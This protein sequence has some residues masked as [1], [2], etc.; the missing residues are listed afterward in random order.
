MIEDCVRHSSIALRCLAI[1]FSV[2][3]SPMVAVAA[4]P[5]PWPDKSGPTFDGHASAADSAGVPTTWNE[6]TG[7]NIAWKINV[8]G[9]GHSTP[10]IGNGRL[11]FTSATHDGKRQYVYCVDAATGSVLHHK[12]LF[13]N[14]NPEP[15][16]NDVNTYASCS[17]YL[18]PDAVYVHFGSYGTARLDP[19]T[20]EVVWQRRDLQARHY[21][22]PGSSPIVFENLLILT[23][24][25]IDRHYVTALDKRTG[26][27]VW[28]T[29]TVVM[30]D[31]VPELISIGSRAAYGYDA[32]TGREL[33]I[34]THSDF[35]ACARPLFSPGVVYLNAGTG[36]HLMAL[37][38]D[39]STRGDVTTSHM[40]WD[41]KKFVSKLSSPVLVGGQLYFVTDKGVIYCV[42]AADG[43]ER[44]AKRVGGSFIATPVV[45]NDKIYFCDEK[46]NTIV[47][48]ASA[49]DYEE[50]GQNHLA[51]GMRAS[52][53][54]ADGA[55][56]LRTFEHLYKIAAKN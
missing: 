2:I 19:N 36:G 5:L 11:W 48:R 12:L 20:A 39:Q 34:V 6:E 31:G 8:E 43:T 13:V 40:I 32:R 21:R 49:A 25:G 30:V 29:P 15:L 47:I 28:L 3:A 1:L 27:S 9:E 54:V 44:W 17:C 35:N 50:I 37:R 14:P 52:P 7:Q 38:L 51:D 26:K 45:V 56:Y 10:V 41:R 55:I 53:A 33:W 24:D 18:E 22:G 42:D 46:G 23:F 4:T 16:N